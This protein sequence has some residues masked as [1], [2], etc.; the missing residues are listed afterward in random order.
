[1]PS[2]PFDRFRSFSHDDLTAKHIVI[3][4]TQ[5]LLMLMESNY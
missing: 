2:P 3:A 1:M 4:G 5:G